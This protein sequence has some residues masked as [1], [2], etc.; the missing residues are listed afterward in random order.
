[1]QSNYS[2]AEPEADRRLLRAAADSG[3][4]VIVNCPFAEDAMFNRVKGQPVPE[5][6]K[7][8]GGESWPQLFLKWILAQPVVKPVRGLRNPVR[9]A[10]EN[11]RRSH[12]S[13]HLH[14]G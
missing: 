13:Q 11:A 14:Q 2:L 12:Q 7:D 1:M 4:A 3:T 6:A 5:W 10:S 8:A 9:R